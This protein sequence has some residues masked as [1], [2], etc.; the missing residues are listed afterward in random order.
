MAAPKKVFNWSARRASA[1]ITITGFNAKGEAMK[2]TGVP[3]IEA[4]KKG[5]GP[6]VTDKNLVRYELL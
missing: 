1:S 4:G 3:V 6:V 2:I 5:R